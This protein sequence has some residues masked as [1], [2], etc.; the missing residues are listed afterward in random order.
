MDILLPSETGSPRK[1]NKLD[2]IDG[3]PMKEALRVAHQRALD[4]AEALKSDI[5]RLG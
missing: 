5:E 1:K 4:T 3:A 2:Q